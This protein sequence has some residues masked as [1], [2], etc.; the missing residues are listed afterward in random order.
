M[1]PLVR[2]SLDPAGYRTLASPQPAR[3][4]PFRSRDPRSSRKGDQKTLPEASAARGRPMRYPKR[5]HVFVRRDPTEHR[6]R[7]H[8]PDGGGHTWAR[9]RARSSA[10]AARSL[11]QW[12]ASC[13][14]SRRYSSPVC[15]V[16]YVL[17]DRSH[18][19]LAAVA[20][21]VGVIRVLIAGALV[22]SVCEHAV[23]ETEICRLIKVSK[24]DDIVREG[25]CSSQRPVGPSLV[26]VPCRLDRVRFP[27]TKPE[28]YDGAPR[29][30]SN[31]KRT[32]S[33]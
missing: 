26:N 23:T 10:S 16:C 4:R 15:S 33:P 7:R 11:R 1:I 20:D 3:K 24:F 18:Q 17:L 9:R 27:S 22:V 12:L 14:S 13:G 28:L 30:H 25:K 8:W 29:Q 2:R 6:A 32:S 19:R 5:A 21:L 31:W